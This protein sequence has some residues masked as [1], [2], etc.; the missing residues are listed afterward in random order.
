MSCAGGE[1]SSERNVWGNCPGEN[2]HIN[3]WT[4][5]YNFLTTHHH[6]RKMIDRS[7]TLQSIRA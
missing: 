1:L 6:P 5:V 2:V 7:I 3:V 4:F